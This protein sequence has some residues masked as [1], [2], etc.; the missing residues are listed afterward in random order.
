MLNERKLTEREL[1]KR[2]EAIKGLLSNKRKLVKKYGRDAE[3]VMYGIATKQA[4][5]K[6]ED[7]NKDK[8]KELIQSALI[9]NE[10]GPAT[11]VEPYHDQQTTT[12][13]GY[14][15]R[16]DYGEEDKA[17]GGEDELEMKGLEE[18]KES[19]SKY[20]SFEVDKNIKYQDMNITQGYWT[21]TGKESAGRGV[22]LNAMNQQMLGFNRED[23]EI[24]Q[25]NLPS[26]FTII[27]ETLD[28][29][30]DIGHEDDEPGMLKSELYRT[31][32]LSSM[33]YKE[34]DKYDGGGEVDFPNWWQAKVIKAKDYLQGAYDYLDGQE[35]VAQIDAMMDLKEDKFS[36]ASMND[37]MQSIRNLAHTTGMDEQEA[38]EIAIN[39]IKIEFG[40]DDLNESALD[41][42]VA[43]IDE[44]ID[45]DESLNLRAI[46]AE[47]E[48][49]IQ[50]VRMEME[51]EGDESKADYYGDILNRFESRL[52]KVQGQLDDY[53][54]NENSTPQNKDYYADYQDIGQFY[55]EGFGKEH[56]L[57]S[58]QLEE[59]GKKIVKQL[60]KG[61]V[62]KAYDDIVGRFRNKPKDIKEDDKMHSTFEDYIDELEKTMYVDRRDGGKIFIHPLDKPGVRRPS[63][64][65][66]SISGNNIT[67]VQGYNSG[68]IQDL[69]D[70]YSSL[71]VDKDSRLV[72]MGKDY[73]SGKASLLSSNILVDAIKAIKASRDAEAKNQQAYYRK[74]PKKGRIGYGL[75]SQPRM[76][77]KL[78]K[79]EEKKLKK[80]KKELEG[81]SKMHAGQ[82]K[83]IAKIVK[84]KLTKG[85]SVEDH[86]EDFKD[87]DAPQF[88]GKSKDKKVQMAVA[89]YLSKK[90]K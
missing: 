23:I 61:D 5:N 45:Y 39:E 68:P 8:L 62:G 49:E 64:D 12:D 13:T 79:P 6:V 11:N 26:H 85:S 35:K 65:Y 30:L 33:L 44:M 46:K 58:D 74:N 1:A 34:L 56:T 73:A 48:G 75:S 16:A 19:E 77:E 90:N 88:K 9:Q 47:L 81:A 69:A 41:K 78:A 51:D 54:M 87:S 37:V 89:S 53:D 36:N 27:D 38:A 86:V 80:I 25:K 42:R 18:D 22:Y 20:P 24:F 17:L 3:K 7:M 14:S 43:K 4:K 2:E 10:Q 21:Y 15:G 60:Y 52:A 82:A 71:S 59:L 84:E 29:D 50:G 31:A 76:N 83:K 70:A 72:P 40:V 57:N 63:K 32:K 66:I 28:E 55:L 67:A